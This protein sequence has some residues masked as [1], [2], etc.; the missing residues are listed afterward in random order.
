VRK[1]M[2]ALLVLFAAEGIAMAADWPELPTKGFIA[3]RPAEQKDA[4]NGDGAFVAAVGGVSVE[5][6]IP[7]EIPQFARMRDPREIVIVIQ[8]KRLNGLRLIGTRSRD[9]RDGVCL[10]TD[11]D[12]LGRNRRSCEVCSVVSEPPMQT[13]TKTKGPNAR[14]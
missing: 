2:A 6:P 1:M 14:S 3:G 5:R 8:A 9:G 11:L 10:D 13:E 12:L 4:A 7:I